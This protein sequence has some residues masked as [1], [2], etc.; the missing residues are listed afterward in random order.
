MD[1][2]SD[3]AQQ[4]QPAAFGQ[5]TL[6]RAELLE[7]WRV[8]KAAEPGVALD[9]A[10]RISEELLRLGEPVMAYDFTLTALENH[11]GDIRLRQLQALA[12][13]RCGV[14]G[15]ANALLGELR[16]EGHADEETLGLLAR[17]Y[18]DL[19]S[20]AADPASR[21]AHLRQAHELYL[22]AY[23]STGGIYSGINAASTALWLGRR[24]AASE[25]AREVRER[26]LVDLERSGEQKGDTYWVLATMGEAY[27]LTGELESARQWYARAFAVAKGR[28]GDLHSTRRQARL[29][30]GSLGLD[31]ELLDATLPMPKVALFCGW[32]EE[33]PSLGVRRISPAAEADASAA[34]QRTLSQYDLGI[35]FASVA[36][37][38]EVL[39]F[40]SLHERH[41]LAYAVLPFD[42]NA[43]LD[44]PAGGDFGQWRERFEAALRAATQVHTV[45]EFG[46]PSNATSIEYAQ[47][48]MYGLARLQADTLETDL[49]GLALEDD[50]VG[51]RTVERWRQWGLE[52]KTL[53]LPGVSPQATRE[54]APA[55]AP[56]VAAHDQPTSRIVA[57]LFADVKGFS[58]LN[59]SQVPLFFRHF[60]GLVAELLRSL[61][62]PP[63]LRNTWGDG[64]YVVFESVRD[65]GLF[66][67]ELCERSASIEWPRKGLPADLAIRIGLHAGPAWHCHDPVVGAPT[68]TGIHVSRAARIEPITPPG[69]A[70]ASQAFAALAAAEAARELA[71]EYVGRTP[72]AKDYGTLPIYHVRR[73]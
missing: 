47:A 30:L 73:R 43:L 9:A 50:S 31:P 62:R 18:K 56:I 37:D 15:R 8:L 49:I 25:L 26:C 32:P 67:L 46:V 52:V 21:E 64:L 44:K 59:E 70:Y 1:E 20:R 11:P 4:S 68:Y 51:R 23:R 38:A 13:S 12:L 2:P 63:L 65:A 36:S 24:E 7:N 61:D 42:K 14:P 41:G 66:A 57:I 33:H 27:L 54:T 22:T 6:S 53:G 39:F 48:L 69:Q 10:R 28:F 40:E 19:W 35:G 29:V 60:M 72:L 45:S 58:K 71:F 16:D 34:I 17:T 3:N 5:V 55:A